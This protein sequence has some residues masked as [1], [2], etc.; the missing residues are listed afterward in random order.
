[1]ILAALSSSLVASLLAFIYF[2]VGRPV[3]SSPL[4]SSLSGRIMVE[5][6]ETLVGVVDL[7]LSSS[8]LCLKRALFGT[9]HCGIRPCL[10]LGVLM[11]CT[12]LYILA[13]T[14]S[15]GKEMFDSLI[16]L[17]QPNPSTLSKREKKTLKAY[18]MSHAA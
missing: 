8:A 1:M 7:L 18:M 16:L 11:F 6:T 12:R 5:A 2:Y 9:P 15:C 17:P 4:L 13:H 10:L 14:V 3:L